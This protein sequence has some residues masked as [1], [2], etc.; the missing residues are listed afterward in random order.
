LKDVQKIRARHDGSLVTVWE[1]SSSDSGPQENPPVWPATDGQYAYE[2]VQEHPDAANP[3]M[4]TSD[5]TDENAT[6]AADPFLYTEEGIDWHL[7]FEVNRSSYAVVGHATSPNGLN[8]TYDKVVLDA[9]YHTAFSIPFK[10]DGT[11]YMRTAGG[12]KMPLFKTTDFPSGW[13]EVTANLIDV[14]YDPT[15]WTLF[16]WEDRW[17]SFVNFGNTDLYAYY[18]DDTDIENATFAAHDQNPLITGD[19][20]QTRPA[21]RFIARDDRIEAWYQD[22]VNQYGDK[23]RGYEITDL[24][25]TSFSQSEVS[26]SPI[27]EGDG[28]GWNADRMHHWDPWYDPETDTWLVATDGNSSSTTWA[29]GIWQAN[30]Q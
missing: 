10:W 7:F 16:R 21:G 4:T 13:S 3:V 17:W 23:V 9:G 20:T 8:W 6:M 28:S 1:R 27:V 11:R 22:T 24:T 14:S 12:N 19:E 26:Q 5:V 15:D 30:P 18:S 29:I 2:G 25:P